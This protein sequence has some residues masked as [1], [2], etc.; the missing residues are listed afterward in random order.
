MPEVSLTTPVSHASEA[1]YRIREFLTLARPNDLITCTI[2]ISVQDSGNNEIRYF[3]VIVPD[4]AHP[5]ANVAGVYTALDTVR[6]GETGGVLLKANYRVLGYLL[7]NGY[8][9]PA[10]LVP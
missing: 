9:P 6:A 4:S 3:S 1:K 5:T 10:T 8:F 2:C 7:D